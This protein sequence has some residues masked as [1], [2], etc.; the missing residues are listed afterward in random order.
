MHGKAVAWTLAN[1]CKTYQWQ[2]QWDN[3]GTARPYGNLSWY[4]TALFIEYLLRHANPENHYERIAKELMRYIEDQFVEWEPSGKEITPSTPGAVSM[5]FHH[6]LALCGHTPHCM[7]FHARTKDN[8]WLRKASAMADTLTV[9]QHADG[10]YPTWM[11]YKPPKENPGLVKNI[12]C[13]NVWPNCTSY[14][15]EMLLRLGEYA[16]AICSK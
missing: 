5:L 11:S 9:V 13:G 2:Q 1:P 10:F 4:D 16:K 7:D 14:T 15:G 3:I 6:R 12:N 8:V